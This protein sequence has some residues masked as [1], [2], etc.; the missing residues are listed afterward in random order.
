M[1]RKLLISVST[2]NRKRTTEVSLSN[3]KKYSMGADI[4][5]YDDSSREYDSKFLEKFGRVVNFSMNLGVHKI[6]EFQFKNFLKTEYDYLYLTDSDSIHDPCFLRVLKKLP[7]NRPI[8][9]YMSNSIKNSKSLNGSDYVLKKYSGG[10]SHFYTRSMVEKI[11]KWLECNE[12]KGWDFDTMDI[13]GGRMLV[14]TSCYVEH[15]GKG[16]LH[17]GSNWDHDCAINPTKYLKNLRTD[18]IMYIEGCGE[19]PEL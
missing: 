12:F 7:K 17:S 13:M 3:L 6:K 1:N 9:L 10:I 14:T 19:F 16:G 15:L 11:C 5:I 4:V 2:F 18:S 8:S